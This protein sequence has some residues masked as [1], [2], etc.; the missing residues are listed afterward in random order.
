MPRG[1]LV[2][3]ET[4]ESRRLLSAGTLGGG[5]Y[6]TTPDGTLLIT[7][8]GGD[9]H[10]QFREGSG[11]G[12]GVVVINGATSANIPAAEF[13]RVRMLGLGGS[14]TLNVFPTAV[15]RPVAA[16]GGAGF[17]GVLAFQGALPSTNSVEA[18][19]I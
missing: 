3:I 11:P 16:D 1:A 5:S 14:D 2:E 7:G 13:Q 8:T 6:A 4:F 12:D 10:I 18:T 9:D 19:A 15:S 17:D